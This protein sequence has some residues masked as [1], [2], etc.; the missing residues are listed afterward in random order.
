MTKSGHLRTVA[1]G[2]IHPQRLLPGAAGR[3]LAHP[4]QLLPVRASRLRLPVLPDHLPRVPP[5]QMSGT[6]SPCYP[7]GCRNGAGVPIP[8]ILA[9]QSVVGEA[10]VSCA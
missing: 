6:T 5:R 1:L 10:R 3:W 4:G 9:T 2:S 8:R 7:V